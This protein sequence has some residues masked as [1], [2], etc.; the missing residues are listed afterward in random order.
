MV[1]GGRCGA[2]AARFTSGPGRPRARIGA[3]D[4]G[5]V[6]HASATGAY[7]S[8]WDRMVA[9]YPEIAEGSS[10]KYQNWEVVDPEK[11]VV[12]GYV[13]VRIDSRGAGRSQGRLEVSGRMLERQGEVGDPDHRRS[14]AR[15]RPPERDPLLFF[16]VC[17]FVSFRRAGQGGSG[18]RCRRC[19]R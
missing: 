5:L 9:S 7:K 13:C 3:A 6:D 17:A 10:N 14:T 15:R 8:A 4:A 11:W 19:P 12:D 1:P 16:I 2:V 18:K